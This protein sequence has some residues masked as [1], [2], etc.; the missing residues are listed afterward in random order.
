MT[1]PGM[2]CTKLI[3]NAPPLTIFWCF[4]K[5]LRM[6][7]TTI[8]WMSFVKCAY[9]LLHGSEQHCKLGQRKLV[10]GNLSRCSH[11]QPPTLNSPYCWIPTTQLT[12]I[13]TSTREERKFLFRI[14]P[15]DSSSFSITN[16]VYRSGYHMLMWLVSVT[17]V[18][19]Y[20]MFSCS[21]FQ[22]DSIVLR[23]GSQNEKIQN[24]AAGVSHYVSLQGRLLY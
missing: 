10:I 7:S 6:R 13:I 19:C 1:V 18:Q 8:T 23:G 17:R 16:T 20:L 14:N 9:L 11:K 5:E 12:L 22:K 15:K 21:I 4:Y 2:V 3:K 24:R